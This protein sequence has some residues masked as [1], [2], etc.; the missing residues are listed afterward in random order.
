MY[1]TKWVKIDSI[2]KNYKNDYPDI[3]KSFVDE[4]NRLREEE[5]GENTF[6]L[7][8]KFPEYPD[9]GDISSKVLEIMP[10]FITNDKKWYGFKKRFPVFFR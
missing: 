4:M 5:M 9:G 3:W 10:D 2:I 7:A 6:R 1:V 8:A